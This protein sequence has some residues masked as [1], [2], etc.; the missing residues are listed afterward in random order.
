[1]DSFSPA[2]ALDRPLFKFR[3]SSHQ[4]HNSPLPGLPP[5]RSIAYRVSHNVLFARLR[6]ADTG[7]S[8]TAAEPAAPGDERSR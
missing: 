8:W 1:M 7:A 3:R 4:P 2:Q 6:K 5:P